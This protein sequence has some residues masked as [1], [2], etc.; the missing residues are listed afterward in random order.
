MLGWL[1]RKHVGK[2][3]KALLIV[4]LKKGGIEKTKSDLRFSFQQL[5]C[6]VDLI[7]QQL[8]LKRQWETKE[9]S[10]LVEVLS[11]STLSRADAE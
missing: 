8:K 1:H 7:T 2:A 6:F 5:C 11:F 4:C 10:S 9:L 3:L